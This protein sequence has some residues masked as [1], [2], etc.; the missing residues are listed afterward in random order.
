MVARLGY[1]S[2]AFGAMN[3]VWNNRLTTLT[4][5]RIADPMASDFRGLVTNVSA[6]AETFATHLDFVQRWFNVISLDVLLAWLRGDGDLPPRAALIT[7]DDGYRDNLT[8]AMPALRARGLEAT[9]F[10][11]SGKIGSTEPFWWDHAAHC[12][13]SSCR[14]RADLPLLGSQ[15]LGDR[16]SRTMLTQQWCIAASQIPSDKVAGAVEQLAE[17]VDVQIDSD[18][19]AGVYM[20]WDEVR[21]LAAN[22]FTVGAHTANHPALAQV[23]MER[24][25]QEATESKARLEAEI[26]VPVH[27]FAYPHGSLLH[28][29]KE[30]EEMLAEEGFRV[31]FSTLC[32]PDTYGS[33]R[34]HPMRIRRIHIGLRDDIPRLAV[35]LLGATRLE[36]LKGD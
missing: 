22:G 19:F 12:L 36:S 20:N 8:A 6:T 2:G 10:V 29:G 24:A 11:T 15:E 3:R 27:A 18:T 9:I 30:H 25:R 21:K 23:P 14:D 7:F 28:F 35:K 33:V 34:R 5:H 16:Y 17:Q 32:G 26:G 4:Y 1:R 31:A 13:M